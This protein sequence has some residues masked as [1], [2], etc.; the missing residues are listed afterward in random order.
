MV[1]DLD[2]YDAEGRRIRLSRDGL[3]ALINRYL[4]DKGIDRD[5]L[6]CII[7]DPVNKIVGRIWDSIAPRGYKGKVI[8]FDER[9]RSTAEDV[10][11]M[12][13]KYLA[14]TFNCVVGGIGHP[15]KAKEGRCRFPGTVTWEAEAEYVF[16]LFKQGGT[17]IENQPKIVLKLFKGLSNQQNFRVLE[18][19]KA[20][21]NEEL[22]GIYRTE[23][24]K[25]DDS[26]KIKDLS[27]SKVDTADITDTDDY[28]Q[29]PVP[30]TYIS[31]VRD[32]L[33][34]V[35][36]TPMGFTDLNKAIGMPKTDYFHAVGII[37]VEIHKANSPLKF[38]TRNGK[39]LV[40]W[41]RN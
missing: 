22:Y 10:S 16:R 7:L 37:S 30:Q 13:F 39:P 27:I 17:D 26:K 18:V 35:P 1:L 9:D 34:T 21:D 3:V 8:A 41:A 36:N 23:L 12:V 20:R 32:H 25:E 14:E 15:S 31:A 2:K 19:A 11:G 4:D 38:V 6:G 24:I 40:M 33:R 28:D 29:Y 5:K